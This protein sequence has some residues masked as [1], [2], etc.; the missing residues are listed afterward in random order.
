MSI[1]E[2]LRVGQYV[3]TPDMDAFDIEVRG[4]SVEAGTGPMLEALCRHLGVKVD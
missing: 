3:M 2:R 4:R 1:P